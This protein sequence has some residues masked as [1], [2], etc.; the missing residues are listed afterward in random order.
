MEGAATGMTGV[1]TVVT[2][3]FGGMTE[4]VAEMMKSGNELMLIPI[5]ILV[6]GAIIGLASR[7]IGR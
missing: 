5:G 7:L 6:G 3:L 4:V 1:M 2:E